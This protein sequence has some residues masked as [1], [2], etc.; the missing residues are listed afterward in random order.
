MTEKST[1]DAHDEVAAP[2]RGSQA[3]IVRFETLVPFAAPIG[4]LDGGVN[5]D[6]L[7]WRE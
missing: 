2:L 4:H 5:L 7:R 1:P 6:S 3:P